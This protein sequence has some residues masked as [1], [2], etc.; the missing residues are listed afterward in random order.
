M[1]DFLLVMEKVIAFMKVKFV[2]Y[3]YSFSFWDMFIW[4]M[5]AG[6]VIGFIAN[7]MRS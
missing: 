1:N 4:F 6:F 2:L 3:G 7:I 5:I